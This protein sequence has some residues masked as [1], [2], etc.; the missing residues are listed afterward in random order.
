[1]DRQKH[2]HRRHRNCHCPHRHRRHHHHHQLKFTSFV[3]EHGRAKMLGM[4]Q[5]EI[6]Q[7]LADVEMFF[8]LQAKRG[9]PERPLVAIVKDHGVG[10]GIMKGGGVVQRC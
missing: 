2:R 4:R 5:R 8:S 3:L 9:S 7:I 1:M 10:T 6:I